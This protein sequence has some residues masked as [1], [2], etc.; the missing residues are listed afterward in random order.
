MN[1]VTLI[2][3]TTLEV[4]GVEVL[5]FELETGDRH[6]IGQ[7][8]SPGNPWTVARARWAVFPACALKYYSLF[9][10][11]APTH[12]AEVVEKMAES[13]IN[14]YH[15]NGFDDQPPGSEPSAAFVF[16][17]RKPSGSVWGSCCQNLAPRETLLVLE[18]PPKDL[19]K[20]QGWAE[21]VWRKGIPLEDI[22]P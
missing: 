11:N 10:G 18:A 6:F 12:R 22:F 14:A 16:Q 19:P 1:K 4:S 8:R 7:L 9:E 13:V 15:L 20:M 17:L 5:Y 21:A 2:E 3:H